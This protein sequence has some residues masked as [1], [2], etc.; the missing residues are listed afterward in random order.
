MSIKRSAVKAENKFLSENRVNGGLKIQV[1]SALAFILS[2][3]I[4]D[5]KLGFMPAGTAMCRACRCQVPGIRFQE[6]HGENKAGYG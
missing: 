4:F 6:G 2:V 5:G 1:Y 3:M